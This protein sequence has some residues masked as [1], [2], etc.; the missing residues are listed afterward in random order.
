[1][2]TKNLIGVV[3]DFH[4]SEKLSYAD[5][6][7]DGRRQEEQEILD[8]I[9]DSFKDCQKIVFMGDCFHRRNPSAT[10]IKKFVNFIEQFEG[11]EL[12]IIAGNH[13]QLSNDRSSLDFLKEV[14]NKNWRIITNIVEAAGTLTFSPYFSKQVLGVK[15]NEEGSKEIMKRLLKNDILFT[16]QAIS[17]S[18][19]VAG[20]DTSVFPEPVLSRKEL[21]K[22]FK[23]VVGGHIHATFAKGSTI[24]AGNVFNTQIGDVG[25]SIWKINSDTLKVEQIPLPGRK[26]YGL[27]DPEDKDLKGIEKNSI[28]KVTITKKETLAQLEKLKTKLRKFDAFLLLE[29]VP[30]ERKKL[31]FGGDESLLEF[32]IDQL[33]EVYAKE[34]KIDLEKVKKGFDLIR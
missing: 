28:V 17:S 23:L 29:Q 7:K 4:M 12:F 32:D 5:Y 18:L 31:H 6:I 34:R 33:L 25:K 20:I 13:D 19:T 15:T 10:V 2:N 26:I 14:K 30:K 21:E 9:V 27:K 8:F 1:M 16:H 11:K 22:K 3:P 24:I